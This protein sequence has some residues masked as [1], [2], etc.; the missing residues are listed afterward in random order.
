MPVPAARKI[1]LPCFTQT[2]VCLNADIN[3][4]L[5]PLPQGAP[6]NSYHTRPFND[7]EAG[8]RLDEKASSFNLYP[9]VLDADGAPWAEATVYLQARLKDAYEPKMGTYAS[10][11]SDLV[12]FRQF[13]DASSLEWT[14]FPLKKPNRPTYRYNAHLRLAVKAGEV[15]ATTARRHMCTVVAFYSWLRSEGV[16]SPENAPWIESGRFVELMDSRGM[17]FT[18]KVKT[19]DVAIRVP[20]QSDPYQATIDDGGKLRP[21]TVEEQGWLLAALIARGNTEMTLIHLFA[22][23]TGARIQ[24]ILTF[25]VRH[26]LVEL[27]E[28]E[29]D[30]LRFAV[31]PRTGVDTKTDKPL[32]L[33]IPVWFYRKLHTYAVSKRAR[34]RRARA[35]GGDTDSQYLFLSIRGAPLYQSR[36]EFAAFDETN[37]LRHAKTGQG[38]RQFIHERLIPYVQV[39]NSPKFAYRFHDL[40]ASYGMNLT[41]EQLQRVAKSEITLHEAREFVKTRMGHES[42]TTT[43][44]YLNYRGNLKFVRQV[45]SE[46]HEY[47][48]KLAEQAL[49]A[50][51]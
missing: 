37:T 3:A 42:A 44:R 47:L 15:A 48:Q 12:A 32:V 18:K 17:K 14:S 29:G 39:H 21:L 26:T 19:T 43:D 13:I 51:Q 24:T 45:N 25:R 36:A 8:G 22:L 10:V 9:V 35:E 4:K 16:I 5:V 2:Q 7:D 27:D 30:T 40:R 6:F 41:D 20:R 31:G 38:V 49:G 1:L 33:H 46:Y 11:A 23:L 50:L 28:L 34:S